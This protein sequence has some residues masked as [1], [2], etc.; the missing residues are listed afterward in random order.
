MVAYSFKKRFGPPILAG[1]K[2]QT[3]RADRKRH[4]RPGEQL[5]LFTGMRTKHC[6]RLGEPVCLAVQP[7]R[8]VFAERGI[9]EAFQVDHAPIGPR[10]MVAFAQA[11]GFVDLDDMRR[12]WWSE[13]PPEEG[14]TLVFEGFLI[15]WQPLV[16]ADA[17]D[18]AARAA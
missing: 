4:A 17:L 5:Q 8:L 9:P 2:A 18:I 6:R 14:D 11:D 15:R 12:F 10:A 1:T 7:V 13:H 3:I 16:P